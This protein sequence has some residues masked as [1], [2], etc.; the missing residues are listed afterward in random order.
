MALKGEAHT[1]CV[2]RHLAKYCPISTPPKYQ[3]IKQVNSQWE[4]KNKYWARTQ[5]AC[6]KDVNAPT[7]KLSLKK[8][9]SRFFRNNLILVE[10]DSDDVYIF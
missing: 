4:C 7:P 6:D 2:E 3:S 1:A 10:E 5:E 9:I 8:E